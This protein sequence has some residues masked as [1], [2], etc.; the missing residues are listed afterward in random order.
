MQGKFARLHLSPKKRSLIVDPLHLFDSLTLRGT[1]E[2]IWEPQAEALKR[3]HS[4][5]TQE[6]TVIDMNTGGGKTL[7]GHLVAQSLVNE[8]RGLVLAGYV[9]PTVQLI[10][11]QAELRAA[12]CSLE[13]ATYARGAWTAEEVFREARGPCITNYAAV[14]NGKSIFRRGSLAAVVFDDA[15][16]AAPTIRSQFTISGSAPGTSAF[17]ETVKLFG[18]TSTATGTLRHSTRC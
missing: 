12:E 5:R 15:H 11:E 3:W 13:V 2:N 8:T 18:P 17:D 4:Q 9:C 1:V 6:D 7:I 10:K 16:V 14:Y